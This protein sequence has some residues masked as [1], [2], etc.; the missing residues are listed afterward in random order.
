MKTT[1]CESGDHG[2]DLVGKSEK[3][4][5]PGTKKFCGNAETGIPDDDRK[6]NKTVTGYQS[7]SVTAHGIGNNIGTE[8]NGE[9]IMLACPKNQTSEDYLQRL[10]ALFNVKKVL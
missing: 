9:T 7:R 2:L 3:R 4:T 10:A 5:G 6:M 8:K 1:K